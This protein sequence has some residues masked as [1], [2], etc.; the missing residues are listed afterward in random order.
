MGSNSRELYKIPKKVT[1][2]I[3]MIDDSSESLITSEMRAYMSKF[4]DPL[5]LNFKLMVDYDK[6]SGLF[7]DENKYVDSALAYLKRIG[8][9]ERYNMLLRWISVFKTFIKGFDFLITDIEGIDE[10]VNQKAG[11]MFTDDAKIS[12][13]VR[14]TSDML[15]QSLLTTWKHIWYDDIRQVEVLP[16]N[17]RRFDLNILI[18]NSGYYNLAIYDSIETQFFNGLTNSVKNKDDYQKKMFP[19]VKKLSDKYFVDN[20]KKYDFNHHLVMLKGVSI[21]NE[22]SGKS[23]FSTLS[24]EMSGE[25]VKNVICM[26]F[27][28]ATYKGNFNNIFGEFDF[29]SLLAIAAVENKRVSLLND[30]DLRKEMTLAGNNTE[31]YM[32]A[33]AKTKSQFK[34]Y[35]K[36]LGEGFKQAGIDT[37]N[38][39]KQKPAAYANNFFGPTSVIGSAIEQITDPSMLVKMAK[40]TVDL[41]IS[42][43]EDKYINSFVSNI[44][45]FLINNF[46]ENFVDVYKKY[47]EQTPQNIEQL[48]KN[49][50]VPLKTEDNQNEQPQTEK[51]QLTN[52]YDRNNF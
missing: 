17:L 44:N 1:S 13:N 49:S 21:N 36:N 8:E 7:A 38:E 16:A 42:Y 23:F 41:G 3:G 26:N 37:L 11:D 10:I 24:N 51:F 14:E 29:V 34:D 19:T 9:N 20:A 22:E 15:C 33:A 35:F 47:I 40:N 4:S 45:G 30:S 46:S 43:V 6:P 31:P 28:F 25:A 27:K 32:T 12:V 48:N 52:V 5:N 39:L 50:T 2:V 18:Y